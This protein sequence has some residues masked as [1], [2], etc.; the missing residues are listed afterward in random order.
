MVVLN[1]VLKFVKVNLNILIK[2]HFIV[3]GQLIL[4]FLEVV[5]VLEVT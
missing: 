4:L 2:T 3:V 1:F 5:A